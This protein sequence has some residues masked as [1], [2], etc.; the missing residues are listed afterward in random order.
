MRPLRSMLYLP[1]S[2]A[3]ALEKAASLPADA[4]ILDLEDAVAPD[5]K[6]AARVALREAVG[7]RG[8]GPRM[9]IVRINALETEWGA[10]DVATI[11]AV[12]PDALLLPKVAGPQDIARLSALMDRHP[13]LAD[14]TIWAMMESPAGILN[15]AA[16]AAS[17]GRM[18]GFVMGTN[19]LAKDLGAEATPDRMSMMHA[20]GQC[21][22]AARAGG[23][24][25]VD[26][27]Y[28][29]FRDEEGLR[30]ECRQARA[31]GF[32]GKTLIHPGQIAT[33]NEIF[34]PS[35]E[36]LAQAHRFVAAYEAAIA[37]GRA[38][39]VVDGR[40]VENLHVET[41]RQLIA[42][43]AAIAALEAS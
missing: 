12:S 11:G 39:A 38:V 31:M 28:N 17:G 41:A 30:R 26:G 15:A 36:D 35:T 14:T 7:A 9:V 29:Q 27:V 19:D 43:S 1:G 2:N 6:A 22:L 5:E 33:A 34:A 20:L 42:K 37:E 32:D 3:R 21:M 40:I 8:F 18:A 25:I 13:P 10:A 24:A 23:I 16:V 4:L